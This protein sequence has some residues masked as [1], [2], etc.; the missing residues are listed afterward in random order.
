MSNDFTYDPVK[1]R[2]VDLLEKTW[3][4]TYVF[5]GTVTKEIEQ[6][7]IKLQKNMNRQSAPLRKFYGA[8]WK[9]KLGL[10]PSKKGGDEEVDSSEKIEY[11]IDDTLLD[12]LDNIAID[13]ESTEKTFDLV[14]V[15]AI[16]VDLLSEKDE[17]LEVKHGDKITFIFDTMIYPCDNIL[18]LKYKIYTYIGIPIFRQHMWFKYHQLSYPM[19][20]KIFL[21]EHQENINIE[22][23]SA[24]Y[25]EKNTNENKNEHREFHDIDGIPIDVE[26]YNNKDFLTVIANDTFEVLGNIYNKYATNEFF[27]VDFN[28]IFDVK[29]I[30]PKIQND[31]YQIDLIYYGFVILYFPMM[32]YS[33]FKDY[34]KNEKSI[35]DLYPVLLPDKRSLLYKS[36]LDDAI[37]TEAYNAHTD[38]N[39]QKKIYNAIIST[40]I[41]LNNSLQGTE[42]LLS[43]RNLFDNLILDDKVV[44]CKA[45]ILHENQNVILRKS[46]NYESDSKENNPIDSILI[47]IR[48][49]QD[50]NESLSLV[51]FRNG[52]YIIHTNWREESRMDFNKIIDI[53]SDVINPLIDKI[54]KLG[55][56]VKFSDVMIV[57][58]NDKNA[59]FTETSSIFYFD[60]DTTESKFN[61]L[62]NVLEDFKNANLIFNKENSNMEYFFNKGMYNYDASRLE[63]ALYISNYYEYLS[64]GV[65]RQKWETVFMRTRLFQVINISSKLKFVISG[66]RDDVE[67]ENFQMFLVAMLII[68]SRNSSHIKVHL[69]ETMKNKSDKALKNLKVQDPVLYNFKKMYNSDVIYSKI[70]QKPYQPMMLSDS[71]YSTLSKD[72]KSRAVKYWNFT[73][74]KPVWYSC[75][76][77][78]YPFIKFIVKQHPRDFCIPCCKKIEMNYNVN[79]KKQDIHNACMNDYKYTGEKVNLT[80]GSHYIASYGKNIEIGRISRLPEKTLEPLFFDTYSVE[81]D[82]DQECIT[83]NG[84]YLYGIEQNLPYIDNVGMIHCIAHSLGMTPSDFFIESIK[85][86]KKNPELF[87]VLLDGEIGMYFNNS[88][89]LCS[90]LQSMIKMD[91]LLNIPDIPW[92]NLASN[93]AQYY[94]GVNTILF[95]DIDKELIQ[96]VLPKGLKSVDEMF[97]NGTKVLVV[98]QRKEKYYPIY[99]LNADIFKRTGIFDTKLFLNESGLITILRAVVG[100]HME[101]SEIKKIK[102]GIDLVA[103]KKFCKDIGA[104]ISKYYINFSN[105]CYAVVIIMRNFE[106]YFPITTSHYV[107]EKDISLVFTAYAGEYNTSYTNMS[108]LIKD[109]HRWNTDQSAIDGFDNVLVYPDVSVEYWIQCKSSIIGFSHNNINYFIS[110]MSVDSAKKYENMPINNVLYHPFEINKLI[111]SVKLG[112]IKPGNNKTQKTEF[113]K[114]LYDYHL[115]SLVLMHF[116]NIFNMHR[117]D[118]LRAKLY[119][120][121]LKTN[122]DGDL[123][124]LREFIDSMEDSEDIHKIKTII[125]RYTTHHDK[126]IMVKETK[127]TYFNFDKSIIT[128]LKKMQ[129]K[130]IQKELHKIAMAFVKIGNPNIT[131]FPN[132]LSICQ[133][134]TDYDYCAKNKLIIPK[135]RLNDII[136]II[137]HEIQD[138][139]KMKWLFNSVS[140]RQTLEFF[141]FIS[142]KNEYIT[143]EFLS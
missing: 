10:S 60:D 35:K 41:N 43:I 124:K 126:K 82:M 21:H 115:Y 93:I 58:L 63:K 14:D 37:V 54:N 70:C 44:F 30:A 17:S 12:D 53:V 131:K 99:L 68:Y 95:E 36:K 6:E 89:A 130:D 119:N 135:E 92:N 80:K 45:N 74:Q 77:T 56:K 8:D 136:D 84:Y 90:V 142:R 51:L 125:S 32:T 141:K 33:V 29:S 2:I 140:V 3:L 97:P 106:T 127:M 15:S 34:L 71:E 46:F 86:I 91:D 132:M 28:S 114:S 73:T 47:K 96:M 137:S 23:L 39:I 55:N 88:A 25:E 94:F 24:F 31:T 64:N 76:N 9:T 113:A 65:V 105:L 111:Y 79:K 139:T 40:I 49:N 26:F 38:K 7:L 11:Q 1:I 103:I 87:R 61:V 5:V 13:D 48:I 143:I 109:F 81:G 120:L 118:K 57:K 66:I 123:T 102:S 16:N 110:T 59:I 108:K 18:E 107:L 104:K 85:R 112:N 75:P 133:N 42:T 20:Y 27:V 98:L 52:N 19:L 69:D 83:N 117:N 4:N 78:K 50:T 101:T 72:R 134:D 129:N 100:R 67:L 121:I 138:E 116:I 128:K 62:K 122:F 22:R